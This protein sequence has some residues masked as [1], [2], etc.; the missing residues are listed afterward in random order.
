MKLKI[1]SSQKIFATV[2]A[3]LS[4][5]GYGYFAFAVILPGQTLDPVGDSLCTGPLDPDCAISQAWEQN[6]DDGYV[7]NTTSNIGIG[8]DTPNTLLHIQGLDN[9]NTTTS[10]LIQDNN[11]NNLFS[12]RNNGSTASIAN[13]YL[14]SN[15]GLVNAYSFNSTLDI[16]E[17]TS[18]TT[19][20]GLSSQLTITGDSNIDSGFN[21]NPQHAAGEFT[22]FNFSTGTID[23]ILGMKGY[24]VNAGSGDIE[25]AR[26]L[27]FA[28]VNFGSGTINTAQG[29]H[30]TT[31]NYGGGSINNADGISMGVGDMQTNSSTGISIGAL[32]N[33]GGIRAIQNASLVSF[34]QKG[35]PLTPVMEAN[36]V[37]VID[38]PENSLLG[39]LT[40][41][42]LYIADLEAENYF[43]NGLRLNYDT[44]DSKLFVFDTGVSYELYFGNDIGEIST[45]APSDKRLKKDIIKTTLS[46]DI[47]KDINII[48]FTYDQSLVNDSNQL[49]HG[50]IAQDLVTIYPYAVKTQKDGYYVVDYT[51]L[52]PLLIQSVQELDIKLE[53]IQSASSTVVISS[54]FSL[55]SIKNWLGDMGNGIQKI[56]AR[57]VRTKQLCIEDDYGVT[58]L[59]RS[60]INAVLE[61]SQVSVSVNNNQNSS[62]NNQ[63]QEESNE[64]VDEEA[65]E[66]DNPES[67][68]SESLDES[69]QS[70]ESGNLETLDNN[71]QIDDLV[72]AEEVFN[73]DQE[74]ISEI[75]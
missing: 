12:L 55:D 56:F 31:A 4:I 28:V 47:L 20:H 72:E 39:N 10:F 64:N 58:C 69:N 5:I 29:L 32:N 3:V 40:E 63:N 43:A 27:G 62:D 26:G 19:Y 6:L 45:S 8:T 36:H 59:D 17:N 18:E 38:I 35:D 57:E 13:H 71:E 37:K 70:D 75:E 54:G 66:S 48:D 74:D 41:Y 68:D 25:L 2:I 23:D 60:Q 22:A 52:T 51:R 73:E 49:H 46:L 65:N 7:F 1:F 24:I 9:D 42:A 30:V 53:N 15:A 67:E 33:F 16:S 21:Q 44:D 14:A 50:V 34:F 61:S 11:A